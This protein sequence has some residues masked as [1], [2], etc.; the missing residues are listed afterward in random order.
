[1]LHALVLTL[2]A[3]CMED[4]TLQIHVS[5]LAFSKDKMLQTF[6]VMPV[7]WIHRM[8]RLLQP[9]QISSITVC[10]LK[11]TVYLMDKSSN[12]MTWVEWIWKSDKQLPLRININ[13]MVGELQMVSIG[14][15]TVPSSKS[16][17]MKTAGKATMAVVLNVPSG[18]EY[19]SRNA[20]IPLPHP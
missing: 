11:S 20:M 6:L 1:M 17:S 16:S 2:I 19:S 3:Q 8:V 5:K 10:I 12:A 7:K 15:L 18:T 14:N 9:Q 4:M 13:L